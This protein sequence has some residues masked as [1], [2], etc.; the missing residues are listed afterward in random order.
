MR[1]MI[2]LG[3]VFI[4]FTSFANS[5]SLTVDKCLKKVKR[6]YYQ[7]GQNSDTP[8]NFSFNHVLPAG[9]PL[10]NS[11]GK[12]VALYDEDKLIYSVQ[13]SYHSGW[14]NDV[15]IVNPKTCETVEIIN[16]YSE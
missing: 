13:G 15:S 11:Q 16:I 9:I 5:S 6:Y 1:S 14:F 8:L 7:N 10:K 12:T 2:A 3:M 4:S